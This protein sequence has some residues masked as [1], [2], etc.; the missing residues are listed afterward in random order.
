[1]IM[2][3]ILFVLVV[4]GLVLSACTESKKYDGGAGPQQDGG[5]ND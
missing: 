3:K 1:M 5:V 2:G 4:A